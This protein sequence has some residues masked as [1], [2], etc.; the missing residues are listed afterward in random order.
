MNYFKLLIKPGSEAG[1]Y[2]RIKFK[3]FI[4]AAL[5]AIFMLAK[6]IC[7]IYII[8][9]AQTSNSID[10]STD[11]LLYS[12]GFVICVAF[13]NSRLRRTKDILKNK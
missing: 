1:K 12:F 8:I 4:A 11:V 6:V 3:W 13:A 10:L 2:A 7:K 9:D 5:A